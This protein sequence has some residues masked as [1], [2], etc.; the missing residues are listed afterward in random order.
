[1]SEKT[2]LN[3][4]AI[5]A[6]KVFDD[7]G[8]ARAYLFLIGMEQ[9]PAKLVALQQEKKNLT[10]KEKAK[11]L[12]Q[13][14]T[15]YTMMQPNRLETTIQA[16]I[17]DEDPRL[18]QA[19][20][21]A[22][23]KD[24]QGEPYT[25]ETLKLKVKF[26]EKAPYMR[27]KPEALYQL[28]RAIQEPGRR[29]EKDVA[30]VVAI[31]A[32]LFA[33]QLDHRA[34][35][36]YDEVTGKR[37][38]G[39]YGIK[40]AEK[41]KQKDTIAFMRGEGGKD[42]LKKVIKGEDIGTKTMQDARQ[43]WIEYNR[44]TA[45]HDTEHFLK[46]WGSHG[47]SFSPELAMKQTGKEMDRFQFDKIT[48]TPPPYAKD[49]RTF[50]RTQLLEE[51]MPIMEAYR[52]TRTGYSGDTEGTIEDILKLPEDTQPPPPKA[53]ITETGAA[54]A[55]VHYEEEEQESLEDFFS[56]SLVELEEENE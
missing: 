31:E 25:F 13:R 41:Q 34:G 29:G 12:K 37:V 23:V 21:A 19:L 20:E 16:G 52:K 15:Y 44:P 10:P 32:P 56:K 35:E 43:K 38:Q 54:I 33:M 3:E 1:M 2:R 14:A 46:T 8:D 30:K 6:Q 5:E 26:N 42:F 36:G 9:V 48:E 53:V 49:Y 28:A 17:A 39:S 24:A 47:Y 55:D 11:F 18:L 51:L 4:V 50:T 40:D 45:T 27:A 7:M 22:G